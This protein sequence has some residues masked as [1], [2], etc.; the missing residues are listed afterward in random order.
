MIFR[1]K[2]F[3][4]EGSGSFLLAV[5]V[6]L[7]IRWAFMEAYVIPSGSMLPSLLIHDHIFVNKFVYGIRF[8]WTE[9]WAVSFFEPQ[10]GEVIV[11]KYP[12]NKKI[13]FIKRVV[14]IP[15]DRIFYENG[16]LY[17]NNELVE[18]KVPRS[19]KDDVNWLRDKDFGHERSKDDYI[20]WEETLGKHTYS[21]LLLKG[22]S[23][24]LA[25][26]PYHVPEDHYF[27]MGDNRDNSQ[28][29]R[30]WSS[31]HRF[32]PHRYLIGRAMF[33]WLSCEETLSFISFLCDPR[34]I[35]WGRFFHSVR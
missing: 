23:S 13:F 21:T 12:E 27:V 8:P 15:G 19:L 30:L 2:K 7:F 31:E 18:K 5:F 14:G 34:K 11:F 3:W 28:D 25:Y 20:H 26:G 10:R 6:A 9:T 29:G 22:S 35:R 4:T 33:V 32:V 24:S 1:N 16:N 17:V